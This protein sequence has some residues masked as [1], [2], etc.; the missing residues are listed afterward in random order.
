MP[1]PTP[2]LT[3]SGKAFYN[4][5]TERQKLRLL[6]YLR[7]HHFTDYYAFNEF[8]KEYRIAPFKAR[9]GPLTVPAAL[10]HLCELLADLSDKIDELESSKV[11]K[12]YDY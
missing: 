4:K 8:R 6:D 7:P 10:D 5:L 2:H 9:I 1:D 12:P 11:D 3:R